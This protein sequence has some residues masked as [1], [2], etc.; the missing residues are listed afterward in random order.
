[1]ATLRVLG[2]LPEAQ[3]KVHV[4]HEDLCSKTENL[5]WSYFPKKISELD[6]F[7]VGDAFLKELALNEA[8][9]KALVGIPVLINQRER[10][11]G[12]EKISKRRKTRMKRRQG[13]M[14]TKV[15]HDVAQ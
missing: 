12:G 5:L 1:M 10:K 8:N 6:V 4:F 11:G 2:V 3:A 9:L 7:F 14:K 13:K 15:L